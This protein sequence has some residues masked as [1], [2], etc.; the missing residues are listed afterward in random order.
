MKAKKLSSSSSSHITST[1]SKKV[2]TTKSSISIP[3]SPTGKR[4][5]LHSL[6]HIHKFSSDF[7]TISQNLIAA[8]TNDNALTDPSQCNTHLNN[9]ILPAK[10]AR[11]IIL[12]PCITVSGT[13]IYTDYFNPDGDANFNIVLDPQYKNM[14]G[15]GQYTPAFF[16]K[17]R[18]GTAL[19]VEVPCQG[20]VTSTTPFNVGACNGYDGPNFKPVLPKMGQHVMVTGRYLIEPPELPGGITE[21]H[22]VSSI[23]F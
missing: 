9:F 11:F 18:S 1:I 14:L 7:Q 6:G 8:A 19:H 17:F 16:L 5:M 12:N 3:S 15:P 10:E 20:P 21:I 23:R 13:V 22:P 4:T 2:K